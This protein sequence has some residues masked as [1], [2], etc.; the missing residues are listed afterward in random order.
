MWHEFVIYWN[1]THVPLSVTTQLANNRVRCGR[2]TE[3]PVKHSWSQ[4]AVWRYSIFTL[5]SAFFC[6]ISFP[7]R[8]ALNAH[9]WERSISCGD[10]DLWISVSPTNLTKRNCLS[11]KRLSPTAMGDKW[12]GS[13]SSYNGA[14]MMKMHWRRKLHRRRMNRY[15]TSSS[16][17]QESAWLHDC[18]TAMS[19]GTQHKNQVLPT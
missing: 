12:F 15:A 10:L 13:T 5:N 17:K 14:W 9:S 1:Y 11:L 2:F 16:A 6:T 19:T 3:K 18:G 8:F 7:F 4:M